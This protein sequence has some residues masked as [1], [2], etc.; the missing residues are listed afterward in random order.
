MHD[1]SPE[2]TLPKVYGAIVNESETINDAQRDGSRPRVPASRVQNLDGVCPLSRRIE[3]SSCGGPE[4]LFIA[5][6]NSS[7][8]F[9]PDPHEDMD[10]LE[11][12]QEKW[13]PVLRP[14]AF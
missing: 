1:E 13:T 10:L 7:R 12:D 3:R 2:M 6:G 9:D 8:I 11:R 14:I 5:R 4:I